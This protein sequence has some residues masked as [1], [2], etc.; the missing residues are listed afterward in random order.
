MR[1]SQ[2]KENEN[3]PPEKISFADT[4]DLPC[5]AT[6]E[7]DF[8][9]QVGYSSRNGSNAFADLQKVTTLNGLASS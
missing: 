7:L 2:L 8:L 3:T 5:F 4:D 1:H 6:V 9:S